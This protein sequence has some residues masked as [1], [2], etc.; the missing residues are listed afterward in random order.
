MASYDVASTIHESLLNGGAAG[1]QP[2]GFYNGQ[3]GQDGGNGFGGFGGRGGGPGGG[4][5]GFGGGGFHHDPFEIFREAGRC[6]LKRSET[7]VESA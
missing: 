2:G 3:N 1:G 4:R 5:G 6:R 7:I